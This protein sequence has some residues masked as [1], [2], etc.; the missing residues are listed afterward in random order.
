M[1]HAQFGPWEIEFDREATQAAY[2]AMAPCEDGCNCQ[3]CRNYLA[4]MPFLPEEVR[5]FFDSLGIDPAFP[6]EISAPIPPAPWEGPLY[7]ISVYYYCFG[8]I[9]SGPENEIG[10]CQCRHSVNKDFEYS[11]GSKCYWLAEEIPK[12]QAME[13]EITITLPYRL[14]EPYTE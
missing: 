5:Q 2:A 14:D 10:T 8:R 7:Y 11:F 1:Q 4:N 13:I 9:V 3:G 12:E 6:F